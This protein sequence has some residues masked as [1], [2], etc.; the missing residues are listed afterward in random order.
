MSRIESLTP[1]QEKQLEEYREDWLRVGRSCEPADRKTAEA[2]VF[3]MYEILGEPKPYVWWCDGPAVGS[4]VRTIIRDGLPEPLR[5]NLGDNL[6]ANLWDS[7]RDNLWADLWD[8]LWDN[9]GANLGDNLR[10]NLRDN[11]WD[12]LGANLRDNLR[13]D[14][15]DNLWADLRDNLWDNLRDNLGANLG[16]NLGANLWDSL[17]AN[18]G[19]NLPWSFWGS[20]EAYWPA[21]FNWPHVALRPM[22]SKEQGERL[23]L[24]LDL[25]RSCGWWEPFKGVVF[26]CERPLRQTLDNRGRL[27]NLSGPAF[28]SRDGW[29][30]YAVH[31]V[32]VPEKVVLKPDSLT[33]KEVESEQNVEIRRVMIDRYGQDRY[34]I[35]SGAKQLHKDEWGTLYRKELKDDEPMVM[36]KVKNSTPELDGTSKNYFLRVPPQIETARQA[37]AW[38]FGKESEMYMPGVET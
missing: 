21:Y 28:E 6:G 23:A 15:G 14:L 31:G 11:L 13:A 18:L 29:M 12:N 1:V 17:R 22:H 10:A 2:A 27:H 30:F 7:L 5:A 36:V 32:R 8:N 19:A 24:W 33:V 25:A 35:D 20:H 34:L 38:S 37:V 16:D 26:M 3:R 9:L 4:I